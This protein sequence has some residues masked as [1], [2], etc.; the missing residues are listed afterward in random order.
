MPPLPPYIFFNFSFSTCNSRINLSWADSFTAAIVRM[1]FTCQA[2]LNVDRVS[3]KFTEAGDNAAI[4][5]VLEFPPRAYFKMK[6]SLDSRKGTTSFE[7]AP[8]DFFARIAMHL[9][10]I[11][12]DLF[13]LLPSTI[14][15]AVWSSEARRSDPA[16]SIRFTFELF[17]LITW[18][19]R[20]CR[21]FY[22]KPM[23]VIVWALDDV[24][25]I[26]VVPIVLFWVP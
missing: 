5:A 13:M 21:N 24:A 12:S 6:V 9:P 26:F 19:V 11:M 23:V 20:G 16:R 4:M 7:K 14:L 15:S 17:S 2:Y 10:K 1:D 25:F 3:S 18:S 22:L 8:D